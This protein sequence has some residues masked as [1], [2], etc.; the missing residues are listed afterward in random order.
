M[1]ARKQSVVMSTA[2]DVTE[3]TESILREWRTRALNV[4]LTVLTLVALPALVTTVLE[5]IRAQEKLSGLLYVVSYL[6]LVGLAVFRRLD[7]RL[8]GWG[9]L[10]M[11]YAVGV[12]GL[13][14]SGLVGSGS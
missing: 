13:M 7:I 10:P 3:E 1:T 14:R 12:L 5:T 2:L 8:R 11:G 4:I 9:F 6:S